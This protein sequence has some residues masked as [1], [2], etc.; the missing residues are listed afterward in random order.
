MK[1]AGDSPKLSYSN[2]RL[3]RVIPRDSSNYISCLEFYGF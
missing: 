3:V 1:F 2:L